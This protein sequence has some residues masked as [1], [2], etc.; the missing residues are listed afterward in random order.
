MVGVLHNQRVHVR[1]VYAGFDYRGADEH[2]HPPL[3]HV[4]HDAAELLLV[5]FPVRHGDG[6]AVEQ[7][8]DLQR[9][10]LYVVHSV[11]QVIHL[12]A[13]VELL[14]HSVLQNAPVVLHYYGLHGHPV[15]R[16]LLYSG[17]VPY[18]GEGHVQRPRYGRGGEREHVH[19]TAHLLD[20]FLVRHAEALLLVHDEQPEVFELHVLLQQPVCAYHKVAAAAL[21]IFQRLAD[22]RGR[23][24]AAE[25]LYLHGIAEKALHRCLIVLLGEHGGRHEYCRLHPVEDALHYGAEG[26]LRLA[27]AHVAAEQPVHGDGLFHVPLYLLHASQLVRRLLKAEALL[28]LR[29][30]GRIGREGVALLL[31]P[32][33]IELYQPVRELLRGGLGARFRALPV[34]AAHF[35][36][37]DGPV[38]ARADV[39]AHKVELRRRDIQRVRP[40]VADFH[41]VLLHPVHGHPDDAGEA[42]DAVVFVHH[43][44]AHGEVRAGA[45]PLAHR[46]LFAPP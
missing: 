1:H 21:Q 8:G 27:V 40:G 28:K 39:F 26:H 30:P 45:N 38:L 32:L 35:R 7:L 15:L 31:G 12:P 18:A 3:G 10:A 9:R 33:G 24:E 14:A 13:A 43:E 42:A 23:A 36:Q 44:V 25:D 37:S 29:L 4:L 19:L 11:V 34:R 6:R 16:R 22:L 17:H 2:L 46:G 41:I 20:M 5:H